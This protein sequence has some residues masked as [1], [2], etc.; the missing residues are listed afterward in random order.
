MDERDKRPIKKKRKRG[1]RQKNK[2]IAATVLKSPPPTIT[3]ALL[4]L[5]T[6]E[7]INKICDEIKSNM[8]DYQ[9]IESLEVPMPQ[10]DKPVIST[11]KINITQPKPIVPESPENMV[12]GEPDVQ[13]TEEDIIIPGCYWG[14]VGE[15]TT[16]SNAETAIINMGKTF[17]KLKL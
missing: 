6:I 7:S 5:Q 15:V 9:P 13:I 10:F 17:N 11:E 2:R 1:K 4:D 14:A 8:T 12:L 3:R 16:P